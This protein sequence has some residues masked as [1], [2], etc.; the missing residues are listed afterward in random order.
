MQL[1][2]SLKDFK[3]AICLLREEVLADKQKCFKFT[4]FNS[5]G[6]YNYYKHLQH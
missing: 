3:F 5:P 1:L 2:L 6:D 4:M